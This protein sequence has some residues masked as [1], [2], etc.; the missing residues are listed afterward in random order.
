MVSNSFEQLSYNGLVQ[1]KIGELIHSYYRYVKEKAAIF[2]N[3]KSG[4]HISREKRKE[5]FQSSAPESVLGEN[6][7][8]SKL[9][10]LGIEVIMTFLILRVTKY[11]FF[12]QVLMGI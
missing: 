12:K 11:R 6:E 1:R 5:H 10:K 8:L 4:L 7:G 2:Q 9:C 3:P